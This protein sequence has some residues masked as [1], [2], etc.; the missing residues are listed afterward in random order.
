MTKALA[1]AGM[2]WAVSS[3]TAF[4]EDAAKTFEVTVTHKGAAAAT[5]T[6]VLDGAVLT[7]QTLKSLG[8]DKVELTAKVVSKRTRYEFK[9]GSKGLVVFHGLLDEKGKFS[10]N[11]TYRGADLKNQDYSFKEK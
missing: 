7:M 11:F 1:V 5:D 3:G 8:V 2:L 9:G 6:V 10:G 4:A